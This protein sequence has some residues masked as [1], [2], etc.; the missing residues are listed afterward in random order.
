MFPSYEARRLAVARQIPRV[1]SPHGQLDPWILA[2]GR[3]R[4]RVLGWML[5]FGY[6]RS[7]A[8]FLAT[9]AQEARHIRAAGLRNPI[10]IVPIGIEADAYGPP[11]SGDK[12]VEDRWPELRGKRRLLF[13]S[14]IYPKK[15]LPLLARAWAWLHKLWPQWH[16]V[17]G[18]LDLSRDREAAEAIIAGGGA[19]GATSFVGP[20]SD[21]MK[22][23]LLAGCHLYALPTQGEN[24]G[25]SIGEAL[26]SG[27]P[28]ITS[29]YTP[30]GEVRRRRCGWW[31][32][33]TMETLCAALTEG[34]GATDEERAEM[35]VRARALI[36]EG[37]AWPKVVRQMREA[38]DWVRGGGARPGH[39][40]GVGE[41]AP[42]EVIR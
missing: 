9:A 42:E 3:P 13:L 11:R 31:I 34:M 20:V 33:P 15:N 40:L 12:A 38:Y 2:Y 32:E 27:L 36:E 37:Y 6:L 23:N 4:K 28:V 29:V 8:F 16:L 1:V 26:A 14:T 7:A 41:A 22:K 10:A 35:G 39:V 19:A 18:G 30:W 17:V 24:F 5:E 21:E 25:I